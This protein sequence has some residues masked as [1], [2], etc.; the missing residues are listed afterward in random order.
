MAARWLRPIVPDSIVPGR[1]RTSPHGSQ[2][3]L[4]RQPHRIT[5][6]APS[7]PGLLLLSTPVLRHLRRSFPRARI[8]L[9]GGEG[10]EL[11]AGTGLVDRVERRGQTQADQTRADQAHTSQAHTSRAH[12]VQARPRRFWPWRRRPDL[13]VDLREPGRDGAGCRRARCSVGLGPPGGHEID[14]RMAV[15]D[16]ITPPAERVSGVEI[17]FASAEETWATRLMQRAAEDR[18]A[19]MLHATPDWPVNRWEELADGVLALPRAH[20]FLSGVPLRLSS[21]RCTVLSEVPNGIALAALVGRVDLLIAG[22]SLA[23]HMVGSTETPS[24]L[25]LT[26]ADAIRLAPRSGAPRLVLPNAD[27]PLAT[28]PFATVQQAVREALARVIDTRTRLSMAHGPTRRAELRR[29]DD[30]AGS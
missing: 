19:V 20:L 7:D 15:L 14:R 25:L 2:A 16:G 29:T 1:R 4:P 18:I 11:L 23:M 12:A 9:V 26:G 3:M 28:L 22:A 13:L 24:V 17:A 10:I 21:P 6:L 27:F 8:D 30:G 5:V